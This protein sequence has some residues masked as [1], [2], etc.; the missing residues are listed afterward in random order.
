MTDVLTLAGVVLFG[1]LSWSLIV[2]CERLRGNG[3]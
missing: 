1:A 2:L 3:R